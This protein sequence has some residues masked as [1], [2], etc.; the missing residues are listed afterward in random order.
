[1]ATAATIAAAGLATATGAPHFTGV[2]ASASFTVSNSRS[3]AGVTA[4]MVTEAFVEAKLEAAE[5]RIELRVADRVGALAAQIS[6]IGGQLSQL[7]TTINGVNTKVEGAPGYKTIWG[8]AAAT[9]GAGV[10]ILALSAGQFGSGFQAASGYAKDQAELAA[11]LDANAARLES[12]QK[13]ASID[14]NALPSTE[15]QATAPVRK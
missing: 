4:T 6:A 15:K 7:A 1:M 9:I 13:K 3:T 14:A 10:A 12:L 2:P 11:R 5:A 8:A